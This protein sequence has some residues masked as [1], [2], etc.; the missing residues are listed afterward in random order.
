MIIDEFSIDF[1]TFYIKASKKD[2]ESWE[3]EVNDYISTTP[4]TDASTDILSW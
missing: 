4:R 2:Q 3:T 1:N